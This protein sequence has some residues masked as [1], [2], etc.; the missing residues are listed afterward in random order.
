MGKE[1]IKIFIKEGNQ[2]VNFTAKHGIY[3]C[4]TYFCHISH[5]LH[6]IGPVTLDLAMSSELFSQ[7]WDLIGRI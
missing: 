5:E 3:Q 1:G 6:L 2:K 4:I 7:N